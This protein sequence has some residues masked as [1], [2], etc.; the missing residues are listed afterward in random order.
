MENK[1]DP[2]IAWVKHRLSSDPG[3]G[4]W[5]YPLFLRPKPFEEL[6]DEGKTM[7]VVALECVRRAVDEY[8]LLGVDYAQFYYHTHPGIF[9]EEWRI[10]T[11]RSSMMVAMALLY[12][13]GH[14]EPVRANGGY[15][16]TISDKGR[17]FLEKNRRY[18]P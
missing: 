15:L 1:S 4:V 6:P 8:G 12:N 9:P 11:D 7:N 10:Y 3:L 18:L 14:L 2:F 17:E 16:L 5:Y 13:A